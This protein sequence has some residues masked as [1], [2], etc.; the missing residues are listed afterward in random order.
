MSRSYLFTELF[1]LDRFSVV[2]DLITVPPNAWSG[3]P[4][5]VSFDAERSLIRKELQRFKEFA[6]PAKNKHQAIDVIWEIA[7]RYSLMDF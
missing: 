7:K 4:S 2:H 6:G 3:T 1:G 5:G